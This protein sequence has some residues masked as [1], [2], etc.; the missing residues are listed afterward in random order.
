MCW[1]K[2][3]LLKSPLWY[4]FLKPHFLC[5]QICIALVSQEM[6]AMGNIIDYISTFN[7]TVEIL[8][9]TFHKQKGVIENIYYDIYSL[10][11]TIRGMS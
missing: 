7:E 4:L 8:G 1:K 2:G 9:H 5:V 10:A 3:W 6:I 11:Q